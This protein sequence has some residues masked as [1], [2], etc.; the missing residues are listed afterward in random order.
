MN[1]KEVK[2]K[3]PWKKILPNGNS[4]G[5]FTSFTEVPMPFDDMSFNIVTQADFLREYYPSGH[6][7][8]DPNIYPDI[9][10]VEEVPIYDA[11]GNDT[12]TT[13][14]RYYTEFVP[15]YSFAFQ[16]IIKIKQMVHLCGN[17]IQFELSSPKPSQKEQ[18]IFN[19]YREGWLKKNMEIA[20]FDAASSVKTTGDTAFVGYLDNGVFGYKVLSFKNGDTLYPHY[21]LNGKL[22]LFARSFNDMD[23]N[24]G[25]VTEW[26]EIWDDKYFYRYRKNGEAAKTIKDKILGIFGLDGY[27]QVGE[28]V[29][30]G[31]PRIPVAYHRDEDGACWSPSQ[32]S[33]DAYEMSF[34][35]MAHNNQA[36]G[37]PT[38]VFQGEGSNLDA[39]YDA[40]GTIKTLSMGTDDKVSY[41]SAQSA[42]ESYMKQLDTIYKMIF[43]QSF[44]VEP[45]ELKSGDL[46][47]AALKILYSP[48][49]EKAMNDASE[50]QGFLDDMV[51]IFSYGYG[52]EMEKTIDF[53][54]L[55]MKWWIEPYVHVNSS[56]VIS[57]LASAVQNGFCS[58][59]T[60]SERIET[61]YTTN[62]EWDRIV[63]E[64]K[65]EQQAD[66]LFE[67][68]TA[69]ANKQEGNKV[70]VEEGIKE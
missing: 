12:G 52:V 41:L 53:T 62:G 11:E 23:E 65:E 37:E 63:K 8:N 29:P 26:L 50:Y 3:R 43:T 14:N 20:F 57:D 16:Q 68:K 15:R 17:D 34:S 6:S 21:G 24:G 25:V 18:D 56:T 28:R 27:S 13:K 10:R 51:D 48:A 64:K 59:K 44:I 22:R 7:I 42:S 36:F 47:A 32:D 60:A 31:F 1:I 33:I 2:T 38:L 54:N 5:I 39:Q 35:Q 70:T 55:N 49:V 69:E 19:A 66:L 67:L 58:K 30:H 45:P 61:L 4:H 9:T 46:P 40:N